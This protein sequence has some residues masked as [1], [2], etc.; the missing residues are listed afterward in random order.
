MMTQPRE[1]TCMSHPNLFVRAKRK[2]FP[3]KLTKQHLLRL[4]SHCY[5]LILLWAFASSEPYNATAGFATAEHPYCLTAHW[6]IIT[7]FVTPLITC[8][9]AGWSLKAA[10]CPESADSLILS[11]AFRE[12]APTPCSVSQVRAL[13]FIRERKNKQWNV[14][15]TGSQYSLPKHGWTAATLH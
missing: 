3:M 9:K 11:Q 2:T 10:S 13:T 8:S 12:E 5:Y 4:P 15:F 14:P 7:A 6:L 1:I